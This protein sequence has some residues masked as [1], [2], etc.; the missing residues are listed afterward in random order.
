[1]KISTLTDLTDII[2]LLSFF[3]FGFGIPPFFRAAYTVF[4]MTNKHYLK[5]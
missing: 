5:V 3:M 4:K 2:L 1:M